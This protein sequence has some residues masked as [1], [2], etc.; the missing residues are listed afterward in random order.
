MLQADATFE[1][2]RVRHVP[3][4][5]DRQLMSATIRAMQRI[6]EIRAARSA[7]LHSARQQQSQRQRL[8]DSRRELSLNAQ[9]IQAAPVSAER[10]TQLNRLRQRQ[11]AGGAEE[12]QL[13][14]PQ[15]S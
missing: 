6:A 14:Q 15:Q 1:L 7:R 4:R 8:L 10:R 5:Y 2:E 3:L 12:R 9:L 13:Q 11:A